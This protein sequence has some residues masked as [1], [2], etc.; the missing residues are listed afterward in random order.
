MC[1]IRI[2]DVLEALQCKG[3]YWT[4]PNDRFSNMRHS[5]F[6][7]YIIVLPVS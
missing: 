2:E 1:V 6:R 5:L 4:A 3:D 7:A